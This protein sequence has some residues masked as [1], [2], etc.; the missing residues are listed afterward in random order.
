[1][2]SIFI[3]LKFCRLV[4]YLVKHGSYDFNC[5][6]KDWYHFE[7]RRK[8]QDTSIVFFSQNGCESPACEGH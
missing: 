6:R 4:K 2:L 5:L 3:C 1:M 8:M 7:K